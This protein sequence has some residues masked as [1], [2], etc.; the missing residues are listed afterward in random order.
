MSGLSRVSPVTALL[1]CLMSSDDCDYCVNT[2][3]LDFAAGLLWGEADH[4]KWFFSLG[5]NFFSV[6]Q[7]IDCLIWNYS[8]RNCKKKSSHLWSWNPSNCCWLTACLFQR[9]IWWVLLSQQRL[10]I[11]TLLVIHFCQMALFPLY[12]VLFSLCSVV[13]CC[14]KKNR[15]LPVMLPYKSTEG[16]NWQF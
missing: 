11:L 6:C 9:K 12:N 3:K 4:N 15:C 13:Q 14:H 8:E 5:M 1:F 7:L 10:R 16:G 2:S